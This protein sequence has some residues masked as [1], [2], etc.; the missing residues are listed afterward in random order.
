ME[1]QDSVLRVPGVRH[2]P[3]P[4]TPVAPGLAAGGRATLPFSSCSTGR[5]LAATQGICELGINGRA[6]LQRRQTREE[7]QR[8]RGMRFLNSPCGDLR[9][10]AC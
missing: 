2:S 6:P 9:H 3:A 4:L 5:A 7:R 10:M 1:G 8:S